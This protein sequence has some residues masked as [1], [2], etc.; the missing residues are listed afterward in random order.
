MNDIQTRQQNTAEKL[1]PPSVD[2]LLKSAE[3][4]LACK[5]YGRTLVTDAIREELA[6][7]R[8][9]IVAGT[10]TA[11]MIAQRT[12]NQKVNQRLSKWK[13]PSSSCC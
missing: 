12:I 9:S 8:A 1:R 10:V 13:K 6:E 4:V 11:K 7:L 2:K 3:M 5:L